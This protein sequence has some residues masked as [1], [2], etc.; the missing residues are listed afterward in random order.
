MLARGEPRKSAS[1]QG[2]LLASSFLTL[3]LVRLGLCVLPYRV[4]RRF[5]PAAAGR[6]D[7]RFYARKIASAVERT[8]PW[9][10]GASC[11]T[12]A[13]AVQYLLARS[14]HRSTIRVG[15][16]KEDD[17]T[18]GAHAWLMCEGMLVLGGT[19]QQLSGYV[20]LTDLE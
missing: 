1:S 3:C 5:I 17:G 19:E 18:M 9:V 4:L 11:L 6:E 2:R 20:P 16:R 10:P 8:A 12:R 15:V 13:I 14:G 7:S